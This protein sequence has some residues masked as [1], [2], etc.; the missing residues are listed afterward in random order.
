HNASHPSAFFWASTTRI[1]AREIAGGT[2]AFRQAAGLEPV[3]FRAPVGLANYFVHRS[4]ALRGLR[5]I[6]WSA[7]GYDTT[8]RDQGKIVG[9]IFRNLR[10]GAI[11]L[12]HERSHRTGTS[13]DSPPVLEAVLERLAAQ[14]YTCIVPG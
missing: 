8:E 14:G 4:V 2:A 7:R 1:A 3:Q 10:P 6:G 5:T 13:P 9:N 12:M 11:I